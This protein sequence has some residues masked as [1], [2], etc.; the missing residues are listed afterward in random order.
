MRPKVM[1]CLG[2]L[3]SRLDESGMINLLDFSMNAMATKLGQL[4]LPNRFKQFLP[5]RDPKATKFF[6]DFI[7][8]IISERRQNPDLKPDDFIQL[9][10]DAEMDI[11]NLVADGLSSVGNRRSWDKQLAENEMIAQGFLFLVATYG[12]TALMLAFSIYE[13]AV[14]EDIQRRLYD[15]LKGAIDSETGE[16]P[17]HV[18]ARLPYLEGV[19]S[20]TLRRYTGTIPLA[21]YCTQDC[22][23]GDTGIIVK[24]GQQIE[25]SVHAIHH[26]DLNYQ[27]PFKYDPDR[28]MPDRKHLI[29][30]YT[31]LQFGA[32][33][34]HCVGM[35][36]ALF[37]I[38]LALASLILRYR[39]LRCFKTDV[40][41]RYKR[42]IHQTHPCRVIVNVN[43]RD[44]L[45]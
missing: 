27:D 6:V 12:G 17:D 41:I 22:K 40:P 32:G 25:I 2:E 21:R 33:P 15:E 44:L 8:H 4:L 30:P 37:E 11:T 18:L 7:R 13:M 3:Y 23:L 19:I 45:N 31:Y 5:K 29:K 36:F 24:A 42:F 1:E 43:K 38:K 26:S 34:R 39:F 10:M 20:E 9:L 16:I 28:F 14:N 35:R